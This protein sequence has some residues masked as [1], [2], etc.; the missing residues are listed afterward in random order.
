MHDNLISFVNS[1]D[2][3]NLEIRL[4][5]DI[6]LTGNALSMDFTEF[7]KYNVD[8]MMISLVGQLQDMGVSKQPSSGRN[9][10]FKNC[11]I[12]TNIVID[13]DGK[14][15]PCNKFSSYHKEL[16]DD[17]QQIFKEFNELNRNTSTDFM[18]ACKQCELRYICA[19]GCRIDSMNRSG[20]MLCT[21]CSPEFKEI[22]YRKLLLDY[23]E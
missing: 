22:Q 13:A 23:L 20:N 6:E 16:H 3:K 15:Y 7:N 17:M 19:G 1:M 5:D 21:G 2:Y 10:K 18:D 9:I 12:G 8:Q 4:N 11:G 14:I